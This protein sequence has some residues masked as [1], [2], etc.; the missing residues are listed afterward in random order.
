MTR[1]AA[2]SAASRSARNML[3]VGGATTLEVRGDT[4]TTLRSAYNLFMYSASAVKPAGFVV[5]RAPDGGLSHR[6]AHFDK[7]NGFA[8]EPSELPPSGDNVMKLAR[9]RL[10]PAR[11]SSRSST[12]QERAQ[13]SSET[14]N[15]DCSP[16]TRGEVSHTSVPAPSPLHV[17]DSSNCVSCTQRIRGFRLYATDCQQ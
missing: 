12:V 16:L 2:N 1:I 17:S 11:L 6:S 5:H 14:C 7:S 8:H 15:F 4:C 3:C 9:W 13:L 10:Q